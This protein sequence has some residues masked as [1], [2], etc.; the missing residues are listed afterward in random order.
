ME[1]VD[2]E[3]FLQFKYLSQLEYSPDGN[4]LCFLVRQADKDKNDYNSQIWLYDLAAEELL[5][6]TTGQKDGLF[7]WLDNHNIIFVSEREKDEKEETYIPQTELYTIN[8]TGGEAQHFTSIAMNIEDFA[9]DHQG[10]LIF[11][12]RED[13]KN[14]DESD[15]KAEQDYEIL[16]ELPFWENGSGFIDKHRTHLF[17]LKLETGEYEQLI[18]GNYDIEDFTVN[19]NLI[20]LSMKPFSDKAP[21]KSNLYIYD[22]GRENLTQITDRDWLIQFINFKNK[23]EIYF[24]ANDKQEIGISSNPEIFLLDL[25]TRE[26][27]QLTESLDKSLQPGVIN[28]ARL[29]GGKISA[30]EDERLYFITTEGYNTHLNELKYENNKVDINRL[31]GTEGTVD[32]FDIK[33]ETAAFIG[34]RENNLQELYLLQSNQ[35][36]RVSNFN[37]SHLKNKKIP[38]PEHFAVTASDDTQLDAWIIKPVDFSPEK[39]YP[40]ILQIHGGPKAAY[41]PIFFHEFQ[42][43]ASR[44]YA[45]VFSN[46]RGSDG[47]G[48]EFLDIIDGYG[49]RD[50]QDL[51]EVMDEAEK[52]YDF[53]D[54]SSLGVAGGSYGGYMTNW[55]IGQTDRFQ[56]AVSMRSISNWISMFGTTDI[57]YF[58]VE[59]QYDGATPW[60]DFSRLWQGSPLKHADKVNT[61]AL[62][63]HAEEDYRCWMTEALQMFTALKYHNVD[64][65]LCLFR[66]ENHEL[67]RGG[68]PEHR[69]KRLEEIVNW[70]D[71][72]LKAD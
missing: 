37:A 51:M 69:I 13:L 15:L 30:V 70:F 2:I 34:F 16:E 45:V 12:A 59:D 46:P 41:G 56:A 14:R 50:Y 62:F 5:Q 55:I 10:N 18:G 36:S 43:L 22:Q 21:V 28:D 39:E 48:E 67:S 20:C 9:A 47:R 19:D 68:K 4:K 11:T 25:N 17:R 7:C 57:G 26:T 49:Q 6:L 8:I 3:S 33:G 44:G 23:N 71:K 40:T 27:A 32:M 42:V 54:S 58:F 29:G 53:I 60:N 31:T 61:P 24:A 72:Y 52:R 63:I 66:E 64:S 65:R 35:E 1:I 38:R